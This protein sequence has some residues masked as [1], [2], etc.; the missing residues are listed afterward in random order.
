MQC[1]WTTLSTRLN[2]IAQKITPPGSQIF[3]HQWQKLSDQ[4]HLAT[5]SMRLWW[6][7][8]E[9]RIIIQHWSYWIQLLQ[10]LRFLSHTFA[11]SICTCMYGCLHVNACKIFKRLPSTMIKSSC[12]VCKQCVMHSSVICVY[13]TMRNRL[14]YHKAA[15]SSVPY[16]NILPNTI[17]MINSSH[18]ANNYR[19]SGNP[20]IREVPLYSEPNMTG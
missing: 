15:G 12:N 5:T 13:I 16:L 6:Q 17:T 18:K 7:C 19:E 2:E 8:S 1:E 20:G 4:F 10:D 11:L 3:T 14:L 9:F